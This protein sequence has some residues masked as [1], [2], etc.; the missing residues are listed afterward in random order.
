[1]KYVSIDIETSGLDTENNQILSIGAI[2]EDTKKKLPFDEIPKFHC[3]VLQRSINGSPFA[4]NMNAE[5]IKYMS[6]YLD[7]T[8]EDKP[9][10]LNAAKFAFDKD[11]E[12]YENS[13]IFY[14][15]TELSIQFH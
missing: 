4:L 2:V 9:E 14:G 11:I 8:D 6:L 15:K 3:I 10:A 5:I 7:S 1:M 12:F 13:S